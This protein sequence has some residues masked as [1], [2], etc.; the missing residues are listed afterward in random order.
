MRI[1]TRVFEEAPSGC[2][3]ET[4]YVP[5]GVKLLGMKAGEEPL[6]SFS[7]KRCPNRCVCDVE[8]LKELYCL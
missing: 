2:C 3:Q 6:I 4:G 8:K 5:S 1:V 7:F